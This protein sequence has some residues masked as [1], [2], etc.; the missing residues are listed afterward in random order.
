M[1]FYLRSIRGLARREVKGIIQLGA[2][3]ALEVAWR[4]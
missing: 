1:C 2:R 3:K 4:G